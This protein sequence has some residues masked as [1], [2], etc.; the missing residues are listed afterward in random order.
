MTSIATDASLII[1]Q[2][3][4]AYQPT[5]VFALFSGGHDSLC[6][7][8]IAAEHP[9]FS[10]AIHINTGIGIEQTREFVRNTCR[11]QGWHLSEYRPPSS[12]ESLVIAHGFPG[13]AHHYKMY[14][15]LKER[16]LEQLLRDTRDPGNPRGKILLISGRRRQESVRRMANCTDAIQV[17][18]KPSNRV[19][20]VNPIID[21][22]SRDKWSY[23]R[24]HSLPKNRVVELLCMSGE[25]LCGAFA[26]PGELDE[27]R[28]HYPAAAE[29]IDRIVEKAKEARQQHC[30]WGTRPANT[31]RF[32]VRQLPLCFSCENKYHAQ[33]V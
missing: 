1:D 13:P 30:V 4:R 28:R 18:P 9:R 16:C 8:H 10:G 20:W 3:V 11:D 23:M 7:T 27:I 32:D 22:C 5:H 17:G 12:Y 24:E 15:R 19:V 29:E 31:K 14:Q 26:K 25:C 6:S 2:A 21:W 33:G